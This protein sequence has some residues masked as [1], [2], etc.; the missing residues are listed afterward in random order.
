MFILRKFLENNI[1]L[2][3]DIQKSFQETF[4]KNIQEHKKSMNFAKFTNTLILYNTIFSTCQNILDSRDLRSAIES[5]LIEHPDFL[6]TI[7]TTLDKETQLEMTRML[8]PLFQKSNP[9]KI[10]QA[11]NKLI[12]SKKNSFFSYYLR[13]SPNY[14]NIISCIENLLIQLNKIGNHVMVCIQDSIIDS[15]RDSQ[16]D[17]IDFL[18]Q[19][20]Q[21]TSYTGM[22]FY[23]VN[24]LPSFVCRFA[25]IFW[26]H[27]FTSRNEKETTHHQVV[28]KLNVKYF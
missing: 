2:T 21:N 9:Q 5:I 25:K 10:C 8:F 4:I 18:Y 13:V 27:Y 19:I 28:S 26:Y 11:F 7:Y 16:N 12:E 15:I 20:I 23:A 3:K 6:L 14:S 1:E 24:S 22:A 17:N